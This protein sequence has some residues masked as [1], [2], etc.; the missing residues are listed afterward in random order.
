MQL[1]FGWRRRKKAQYS[2]YAFSFCS[3]HCAI[4]ALWTQS[5]W[6]WF[7]THPSPCLFH[8]QPQS[9]VSAPWFLYV[10]MWTHHVWVRDRELFEQ[11]SKVGARLHA[12]LT[13]CAVVFK[14]GLH[15]QTSDAQDRGG[16]PLFLC[17][18]QYNSGRRILLTCF[19]EALLMLEFII[20]TSL[21][22]L[23]SSVTGLESL[24]FCSRL[25]F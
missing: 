6:V 2:L 22:T 21:N 16:A 10:F 14:G 12:L 25:K 24:A 5:W 8:C 17:M 20:W 4:I 9:A 18:L 15:V 7:L 1:V 23:S 19:P 13:Y 3:L 11:E